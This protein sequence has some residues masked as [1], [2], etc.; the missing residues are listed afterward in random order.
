ME[1][2]S[3]SPPLLPSWSLRVSRTLRESSNL[4]LWPSFTSTANCRAQGL[5]ASKGLARLSCGIG[6]KMPWKEQ[7]PDFGVPDMHGRN[8]QCTLS[9]GTDRKSVV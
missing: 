5:R 6:R 9:N 8:L 7:C 4:V 2:I 3:V 1:L